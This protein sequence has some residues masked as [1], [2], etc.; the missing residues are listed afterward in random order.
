MPYLVQ[1]MER[2]QLVISAAMVLRQISWIVHT[3]CLLGVTVI[4]QEMLAC[5]VNVSEYIIMWQPQVENEH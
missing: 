2:C 1:P 5:D 4:T 3:Q